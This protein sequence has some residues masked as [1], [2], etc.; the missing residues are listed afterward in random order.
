MTI[1]ERPR[2]LFVAAVL[3]I[4]VLSAAPA[5]AISPETLK[6]FE[7][8]RSLVKEGQYEAAIS[9][10][11]ES[12]AL[13]PTVGALLNLGDC[14]ERLNK[15][16]SARRRF[17]EAAELAGESDPTRASEARAR[18]AK[19]SD[20]IGHVVLLKRSRPEAGEPKVTIDGET[21]TKSDVKLPMDPGPHDVVITYPESPPTKR[22]VNVRAR[23][24]VEVI[25]DLPAAKPLVVA[26]PPKDT[27]TSDDGWSTTKTV[28][29][30]T[31]IA[32]IVGLGVG[33]TF[34]VI[35]SGKKSDLE[36]A[37][38]GY[39]VCP[40]SSR[41]DVQGKYDDASSAATISTIGIVVGGL[42]LA[43][44]AVLFFTAPSSSKRTGS[45]PT[46]FEF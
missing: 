17:I 11:L 42:L 18:A 12:I 10:F 38:A 36:A 29:F 40:E 2:R 35:A 8:G 33:V 41:S 32:G 25:L 3:S 9:K 39:P 28:G 23:E 43:T 31:G 5:H 44:G 1:R 19:L 24:S 46:R 20:A 21:I 22:T 45:L 30:G 34:G 15:P 13:E 16:A 27:T 26:P 4:F 6:A 7:A 37:C 14:Y